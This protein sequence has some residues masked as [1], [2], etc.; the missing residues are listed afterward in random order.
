M[1]L[2]VGANGQLGSEL[3][4][5]L[6]DQARYLDRDEL[7]ITDASAVEAFIGATKPEAIVNCAAYTAVDKAESDVETARKIN[8]DGVANLARSAAV[9]NAG[10]IHISTDYVFD[11][12]NHRPYNEEDMPCPI[13]VYGKTKYE[14]EEI[15]RR[16]AQSGIIIRTAWLYSPY[17]NNF[18]KTM[19]R[20]GRERGKLNVVFDQI[21]TPTFAAD[22]AEVIVKLLPQLPKNKVETYHYSNEGVASW[23]DF[24]K[25]IMELSGIDCEVLPIESKDYPTAASRPFY[26]VL[27]KAKIKKDFNISINHWKESLKKCLEKLS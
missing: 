5:I 1:Y 26:S 13:S 16:L 14:G 8:V 11:G 6:K 15:M 7:D 4:E 23:Y 17:G 12:L 22:L 27:N 3:K 25:E 21:G 18:V 2:I 24:A 10:L 19:Q 20:L 9:H